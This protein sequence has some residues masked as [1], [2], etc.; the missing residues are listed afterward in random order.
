MDG[1]KEDAGEVDDLVDDESVE[2]FQL[3]LNLFV[4]YHLS[5][6]SAVKRDQYKDGMVYQTRKAIFQAFLK[7]T[8]LKK[9]QN[10][11]CYA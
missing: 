4:N 5:R 8:A 2:E 10:S 11:G 3:R 9:C 6:A 7:D 1:E